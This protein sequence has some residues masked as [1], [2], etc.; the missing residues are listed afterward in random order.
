MKLSIVTVTHNSAAVISDQIAS[1]RDAA[2]DLEI[3]QI[4]IDNAST[5]TTVDILKREDVLLI[6]NKTNLGFAAANNQALA[7]TTGE[8]FLFLNPDMVL[9]QGSLPTLMTWM[10]QESNVGIAGVRLLTQAGNDHPQAG[11][12][13]FP[14]V[15]SLLIRLFKLPHLFPFLMHRYE[16]RN[17]DRTRQ[18]DVDSLRGSFLLVRREIIETLGFA[19]DPR[20]FIWFDDVD[21]CKEAHRLGWRVVY[22]PIISAVDI[23]GHSFSQVN[24]VLNQLRFTHSMMAYA[25]KWLPTYQSLL[26]IV[27]R[28]FAIFL[29]VLALPFVLVKK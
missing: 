5:D 3:E 1:I 6:E 27:A 8:F 14:T 17:F 12:R 7:H 20:Y 22:T 2:G 26:L 19:F 13:R 28:P 21:L 24:P 10:E 25:K 29:S 9:E 4:I 18:A 11:P 15:V 23:V 16:M